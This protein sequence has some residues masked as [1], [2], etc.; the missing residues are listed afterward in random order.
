MD[1]NSLENIMMKWKRRIQKFFHELNKCVSSTVWILGMLLVRNCRVS[2]K[3]GKV[4]MLECMY[5]RT[6]CFLRDDC[7]K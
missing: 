5:I 3:E 4:R 1:I 6:T 2:K 7:F